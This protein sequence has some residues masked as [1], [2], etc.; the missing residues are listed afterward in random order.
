MKNMKDMEKKIN[1]HKWTLGGK[2]IC[3]ECGYIANEEESKFLA[4]CHWHIYSASIYVP[5]A[6]LSKENKSS[7]LK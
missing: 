5:S 4:S 7:D 1:E 6:K 2:F 3:T